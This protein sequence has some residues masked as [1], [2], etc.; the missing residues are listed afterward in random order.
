MI[1]SI[2]S[3]SS[4]GSSRGLVHYLAHSKFDREKEGIKRRE[5]FNEFENDLDVRA[6]NKHLSLT[7]SKPNPEELLHVV[8]APSRQEIE[9]IGDDQRTRKAA[10]KAVV[11][12]TVARLEKEA[13][14]KNLRWVAALHFNTDNPHAHLAVQKEFLSENGKT[15]ILR[16][17]RQMLH[18]NE[19]DE[20]GE[21]K[22]HKGALILAAENK[23]EELAQTRLRANENE[24]SLKSEKATGKTNAQNDSKEKNF[25][26]DF[27]KIPNYA[28]RRILAEEMLTA[29]EI[30]RR[31]GN[32]ENL[33]EHG[34][35]KRFKIKDE[36][37]G[38]TRHVSLFDI[39]RKIETTSRR[40]A[41][42]KH[43]KYSEKHEQFAASVAERERSKYEPTIR[44]LETIRRHVLG[45]ENRHLS[46]TEEKHTRLRNQKLLIE[47]KY[48][49]LKA[50]VPLPLFS[51]D[52][53]QRLQTEAIREQN[54]EKVLL[55][56]S[57]RQSNA[58]ELNRATRRDADVRELLAARIINKLKTEGAEKR[59]REFSENKD[60][61]KVKIGDSLLSHNNLKRHELQNAGKNNLWTQ[62]KSK[63]SGIL[64]GPGDKFQAVEKLDYPVLHKAVAD[65][66]E[67]LENIRR[68]EIEKQKNFGQ[69]LDKIFETETNPNKTKLA[70]RFSAF[71]VSLAEDLARD[72]GRENFYENSLRLQENWLREKSAEK[73]SQTKT[74][75]GVPA[76]GDGNNQNHASSENKTD[77]QFQ[78]ETERETAREKIIGKFVLGRAEARTLLARITVNK[79]E[80]NLAKYECDRKF[81]KHRITDPK[82]GATRDLSLFE[83]EPR[84]HYYLLDNLLEKALES[85]EQ[86]T[87]RQAVIEASQ[88]KQQ[89]L[90][91]NLKTANDL[92]ERLE[93]RKT[94]MLEKFSVSEEIKPIF[95]PKEIA[96]LDTRA[97]QTAN[98]SEAERL[99]K[100]IRETEKNGRVAKIEDWLEAA[101]NE[102]EILAPGL[103]RKPDLEISQNG[104]SSVGR[105]RVDMD[106]RIT[107]QNP[108]LEIS[109]RANDKSTEIETIKHENA[110]VR[111]KG[112]TR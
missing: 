77:T 99:E 66:L 20:N 47:K 35:K 81:I 7:D 108:V 18:Y 19:R 65:A 22:L 30:E 4:G 84:K 71:E 103:V 97:V 62:I 76:T 60:Y 46:K 94:A 75:E 28:E 27:S 38:T 90:A 107:N 1:I 104:G 96:A 54:T 23:I 73:T 72:A 50:P 91:A 58:L 87:D 80:E 32:I 100:L 55:F 70:P 33:I 63:T 111:E 14:A 61:V 49:R 5:F 15:E 29:S 8:I 56:E 48:E 42:L 69:T 57:F 3:S 10:L 36:R 17:N 102:L 24:K 53:I 16:I 45:F 101:A 79:A 86:K 82:T 11:R 44:A 98:K 85:K 21:K 43:P 89:E 88:K 39:E 25:A 52:E 34:D 112:R 109:T 74:Q 26:D 2:K 106:L 59:F 92:A 9:K 68:D 105:Q 95:T 12:E 64:F 31:N 37:T 83:T 110:A 40:E 13:K 41:W 78:S 51:S 93:N 6:A 67:N